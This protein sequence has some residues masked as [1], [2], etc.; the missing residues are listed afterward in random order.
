MNPPI[1]KFTPISHLALISRKKILT[2]TPLQLG[3]FSDCHEGG[4]VGSFHHVIYTIFIN[5]Y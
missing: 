5:I 3:Q 2:P 1:L 4:G